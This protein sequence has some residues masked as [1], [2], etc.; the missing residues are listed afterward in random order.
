V[1]YRYAELDLG[2]KSTCWSTYDTTQ[3]NLN[4]NK[5]NWQ[6]VVNTE[7]LATGMGAAHEFMVDLRKECGQIIHEL[8]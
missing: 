3:H 1:A 2:I 8:F 6:R 5:S 4:S 7:Y